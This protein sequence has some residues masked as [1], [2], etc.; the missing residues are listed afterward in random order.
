MVNEHAS[1]MGRSIFSV[2]VCV[3]DGGVLSRVAATLRRLP[4][5]TQ[6]TQ[7]HL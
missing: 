3:A 2:R 6:A 7:H 5:D 4:L 1:A